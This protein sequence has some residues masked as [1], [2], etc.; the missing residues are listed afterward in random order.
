MRRAVVIGGSIAGLAAASAIA[1]AFDEVVVVE[2]DALPD[3]AEH[4]KGVPQGRQLHVVLPLGV[5]VLD[6]L[7]PGFEQELRDE[8]CPTFDEVRDTPWFGSQGWR[9]RSASDVHLFGFSRPLFEHLLRRRVR[10]DNAI[11]IIQGT[12]DGLLADPD[13][14]RVTGVSI[15]RPAATTLDAELVVDAGGRGSQAPKWLEQLGYERPREEHVRAH[16]GYA[17][18]LVKVPEG[19]MPEGLDGLITMPFPGHTKGGLIL[20]ADNGRHTLCGI[21]AVKDYPPA[22]EE[23][24]YEYLR[25]A[26]SPL[27]GEIAAACEPLTEIA[28]YHHPGNQRRLW[29]E[30]ERRP[31]GFVPIGDAV[32]SFNPIYGQ[33]MTVA[34]LEASKLRD[35]I[36]TLDG[37]LDAL[38]DAFQTDLQEAVEFPYAM[39][40][41]AD[42]AYPQTEFTNADRAPAENTEF[43]AAV[44][45][46]ATEDPAVARDILHATGW[47]EA[48]LLASPQLVEKVGAWAAAGHEVINN[49]PR[50]VPPVVNSDSRQEVHR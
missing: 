47:F 39:A 30:L 49:D 50:R 7:F 46:V 36:A 8:G 14:A 28:T 15:S 35:R 21:G 10:A 24:F 9:A 2:R 17:S 20:P 34:A 32:A 27:L 18:R 43:F 1:A 41:G 26:P 13:G 31:L 4:R 3:G 37:D 42:S 5:R 45:Q 23:G 6:Q 12:V 48:E 44:E 11:E 29:A 38:P 19:A 16:F 22:D 40:T 33:G 25:Q